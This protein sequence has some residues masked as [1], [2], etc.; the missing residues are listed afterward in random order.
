[1]SPI[2]AQVRTPPFAWKWAFKRETM[3]IYGREAKDVKAAT[4]YKMK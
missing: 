2:P 3:I 4:R 1:M